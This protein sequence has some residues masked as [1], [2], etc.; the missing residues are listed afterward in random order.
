MKIATVMKNLE[1]YLEGLSWT[2]DDG[3]GT[4]SF[5]GVYTFPKFS[6]VDGYPFVVILDEIGTG[7][8]I[9]NMLLEYDTTIVLSICVNF[10]IIDKQD[11]DLKKEE[12]LLR[13]REAWD[14]LKTQLFKQA[15]MSTL[16]ID[17]SYIP[18]YADEFDEVKNLYKRTV[19]LVVKETIQR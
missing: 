13:L 10:S 3:T 1:T 11:T 19:R 2:S 9:A 17:W 16:G 4:T 14:Y 7:E 6:G 18:S 15:T 12:A 8:S 5:K